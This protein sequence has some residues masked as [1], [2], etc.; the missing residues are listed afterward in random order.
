[1][2]QVQ[3]QHNSRA[4][5]GQ[6]LTFWLEPGCHYQLSVLKALL[7]TPLLP[8]KPPDYSS[9]VTILAAALT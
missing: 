8:S 1:M 3:R 9:P 2:A 6:L 5:L 7:P 4:E